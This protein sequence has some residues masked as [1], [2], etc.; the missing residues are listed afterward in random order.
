VSHS[1]VLA[2]VSARTQNLVAAIIFLFPV[3]ILVLRPADGL[4]LGLLALA[5]MGLAYRQRGRR[6]ASTEESVLYF[7]LLCF[8]IV[9]TLATLLGGIDDAGLRKLGKFARLLLV[10]PVYVYLRRVGVNLAA[11]WYG[12]VAGAVVAAVTAMYQVW[13]APQMGRAVGITHPIIFGDLALIMGGMALAGLGWFRQRGGWQ[14]LLPVLAVLM[15]L[16]ASAL[17]QS[18]GGW[19]AIPFLGLAFLWYGR[20]RMP[21]WQ[22]GVALLSLLLVVLLAYFIP[23]TG[24]QKTTQRTTT[25]LN[26]YF[27]SDVND[28]VRAS[29][30]GSRLEM[31]QAAWHIYKE[32][33]LFGVGWGHY[34]ASAQAL[35]DAGLR[36]PSVALW[37]H[38]HNQ[39]L[40]AMASG[41]SAALVALLLLFLMPLALL[42]KVIKQT[43]SVDAQRLAFAGVLLIIGYMSFG[44]S[45]AIIERARP[46]S[47]FGFYIAVIFAAIDARSKSRPTD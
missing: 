37:S 11:F 1:A 30:V 43:A 19:L 40:S 47:F 36:N 28:A 23:V 33:P 31:W 35:S 21:L 32:Q 26:A 16:L 3:L 27:Q 22:S 5:G 17:S 34:R 15:A 6:Q 20:A 7:A 24:V 18:R 4:G 13:G 41:G 39:F 46:V 12:L 45:E 44:F 14:W 9:A 42:L 29:S 38:P 25:N 10:I 2:P 8:F